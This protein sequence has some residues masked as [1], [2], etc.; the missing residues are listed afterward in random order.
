MDAYLTYLY[1]PHPQSIYKN[2]KKLSPAHYI[3]FRKD[4]TKIERYWF[5][6]F[7]NKIYMKEDE[8]IHKV[9]E[10]LISSI[11][12][13]L[14]SDV[15]LG[16]F[17][18]GG[19]DSSLVVALMSKLSSNRVKTFSVGFENQL[20]NELPYAKKVADICDFENLLLIQ[21]YCSRRNDF[22][23]INHMVFKSIGYKIL[24]IFR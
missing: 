3:V 13:R 5:L 10:L 8:Y 6:S 22:P 12:D 7:Q 17:L 24:H 23:D 1:V 18:S 9:A 21:D 14:A 16:A 20:Y 11:K 2:I 15:P 4:S 19:I